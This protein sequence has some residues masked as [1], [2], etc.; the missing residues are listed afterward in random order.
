LEKCQ[1]RPATAPTPTTKTIVPA[2]NRK[3]KKRSKSL[4]NE[5]S[6]IPE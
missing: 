4:M 3:P 2:A 5:W 6:R 1:S